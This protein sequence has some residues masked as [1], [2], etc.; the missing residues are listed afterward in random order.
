ML[1][2]IV[3]SA[4]LFLTPPKELEE[5]ENDLLAKGYNDH[6]VKQMVEEYEKDREV[7]NRFEVN[8]EKKSREGKIRYTDYRQILGV[9]R[10]KQE[11]PPFIENNK[12]NLLEAQRRYDVDYRYIASIIGVESSFNEVQGDRDVTNT[13]LTIYDNVPRMKDF[14]KEQ[15]ECLMELDSKKTFEE[16][17]LELEGSYAGAMGAGQF[18]PCSVL[19]YYKGDIDELDDAILSVGNY[20][21]K[22]GWDAQ[23]NSNSY[24]KKKSILMD[25]NKSSVYARAVEEIANS[26]ENPSM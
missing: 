12:D 16:D 9:E 8:P 14:A 22:H 2:K 7:I 18:I 19:N 5:L 21:S 1:E 25:Y 6:T 11:L 13:L 23:T 15:I 24:E 20:L 17:V 10:L 26:V 4:M 3:L